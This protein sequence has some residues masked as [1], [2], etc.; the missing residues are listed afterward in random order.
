MHIMVGHVKRIGV[1][2]QSLVS[3]RVYFPSHELIICAINTDNVILLWSVF[4]VN[5]CNRITA[6]ICHSGGRLDV[7][8][9]LKGDLL[10]PRSI[11]HK[12]F[13][14]TTISVI[15]RIR[16]PLPIIGDGVALCICDGTEVVFPVIYLYCVSADFIIR[17]VPFNIFA[18][19]SHI[20][21]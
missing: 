2:L 11:L 17:Y 4:V 16:Q 19:K 20:A 15:L 13:V 8:L 10:I 7:I 6:L 12:N 1:I 18:V 3:R 5:L 14:C 9:F 21:T